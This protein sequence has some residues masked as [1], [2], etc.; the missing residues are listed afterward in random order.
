MHLK[1]LRASATNVDSPISRVINVQIQFSFHLVEE[2]WNQFQPPSEDTRSLS[3]AEAELN[4]LNLCKSAEATGA[5]L[6]TMWFVGELAGF[7]MLVLLD[8]G[9]SVSFVS[10][11]IAKQCPRIVPLSSPLWVHVANGTRVARVSEVLAA[12]WSIQGYHFISNLKI[13]DIPTYDMIV[14]MDWLSTHSPMV[15]H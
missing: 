13:L 15:V 7:S 1:K 6:K 2:L 12:D 14:G 9:S 10:S 4:V 11:T 8:S 3:E 5:H